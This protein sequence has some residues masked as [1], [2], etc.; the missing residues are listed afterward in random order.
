MADKDLGQG[1]FLKEWVAYADRKQSH[2][3][4]ELNW[5]SETLNRLWYG[6]QPYRQDYVNQAAAWLGIQPYELLMPP[7]EAMALRRLRETARLIAATAIGPIE[8]AT[9]Q[10]NKTGQR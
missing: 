3:L 10:A 5:H 8:P 4:S 7:E 6:R 1:W 9:P 2:L